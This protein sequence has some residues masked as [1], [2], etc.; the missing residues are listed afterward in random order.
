MQIVGF[1]AGGAGQ[2]AIDLAAALDE[3][4]L[5]LRGR[6]S[7]VDSAG[8]IVS[9]TGGD[10]SPGQFENALY[11]VST[12]TAL[13]RPAALALFGGARSGSGGGG[14]G[15]ADELLDSFRLVVPEVELP[16]EKELPSAGDVAAAL[17]T[18]GRQRTDVIGRSGAQLS[19]V[20]T[21]VTTEDDVPAAEA[22]DASPLGELFLNPLLHPSGAA[23]APD[24][25]GDPLP[26]GAADAPAGVRQRQVIGGTILAGVL[27]VLACRWNARAER[28]WRAGRTRAGR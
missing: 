27:G 21:V 6:P 8:F 3:A 4:A 12:G 9:T 17:L 26:L 18:G 11:E 24:L 15:G 16:T 20:A 25:W 13:V 7:N 1:A 19:A 28:D 14:D 23:P 5:G 10:G 2:G 22:R